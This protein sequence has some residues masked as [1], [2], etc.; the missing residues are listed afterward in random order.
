MTL[1]S[2]RRFFTSVFCA[3]VGA[4]LVGPSKIKLTVPVTSRLSPQLRRRSGA[5]L[6]LLQLFDVPNPPCHTG[7]KNFAEVG[8]RLL[9][10]LQLHK[11]ERTQVAGIMTDEPIVIRLQ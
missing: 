3:S 2:S 8:L 6:E 9:P 5:P 1:P 10:L 11:G 4:G 7:I